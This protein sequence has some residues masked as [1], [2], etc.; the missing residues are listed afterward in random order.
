MQQLLSR[1]GEDTSIELQRKEIHG[2]RDSYGDITH[3]VER[4]TKCIDDSLSWD[5]N[6]EN[7]FWHT[8]AYLDLCN[9]NGIIFNKEMKCSQA[10]L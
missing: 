2:A 8:L 9:G 10:S 7:S 5:S 6:I 4:N 1:N 3:G